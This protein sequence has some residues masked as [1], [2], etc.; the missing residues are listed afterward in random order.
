MMILPFFLG[1]AKT[2]NLAPMWPKS[3]DGSLLQG[4]MVAMVGVL[5]AYDGWVNTSTLAEE[6]RDPGR[7]VPR[8]MGAGMA[9]LIAVYLGMTLV[10]HMVLPMNE[11][12][13]AATVKGSPNIVAAQFC[14]K[15]LGPVG[16]AAVSWLVVC[17][18]L[19]SLNGNALSGPRA[20]FAMA[21]DGLFPAGLCRI[22]PRFQTPANAIIAQSV[23]SIL[24][25]VIG[26]VFLLVEPP[27][28]STLPTPLRSMWTKLHETPLYDVLYSYVI[29]GGTV[30]YTLT[31]T[32]VFVL[33]ASRPDA[34][35]PYKAWGYPFTPLLYIAAACF[36][37]CGMLVEK[38][39]ESFAGLGIILLGIPAYLLFD[40]SRKTRAAA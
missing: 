1:M 31:I 37:M 38:R 12:T 32:S 33:R 36:L 9:I 34:V 14:D 23:W 10:Y 21:R 2:T 20:Y 6:I 30:I 4:M 17:S 39:G 27:A 15:L 19:I 7:N 5:W 8:A 11:I 26:T 29:F 16:K 25:T 13:G 18:T 40:S 28:T 22:H 3:Y 35:R 24:L